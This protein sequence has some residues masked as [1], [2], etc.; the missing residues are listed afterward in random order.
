M[1]NLDFTVW[2]FVRLMVHLEES[3]PAEAGDDA[4]PPLLEAWQDIWEPL[5]SELTELGES[6][7]EAYADM[8]MDQDVIVEDVPPAHVNQA[9]AGL[10]AVAG[11][12]EQEIAQGPA[13]EHL[14]SLEYERDSLKALA[15]RFS[16]FSRLL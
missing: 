2:Q 3:A 1:A 13:P 10:Q 16:K 7:F 9:V 11:I 14:E 6:D 8:M 5:D 15:K 4:L 12:L